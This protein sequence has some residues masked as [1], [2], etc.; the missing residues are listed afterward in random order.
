LAHWL[1]AQALTAAFF[2]PWM[3]LYLSGASTWSAAPAFDLG[4]FLR[5]VATVLPLGVTTH[6]E[7]YTAL[8]RLMTAFAALG[9]IGTLVT[10]RKG[11]GGGLFVLIVLFP[12][13]LIYLLSLTPA[14]FFAPKIQARYLLILLPAY[15]ILLA[16]GVMLLRRFSV[17]AALLAAAVIVGVNLWALGDYYAERRLNDD[18]ATLANTINALAQRDDVVLLNTDQE[19][20]TFLY[21][22]RPSIEWLGAPNGAPM[23]EENADALVRRALVRHP[24]VWVVSIPDALASD[25]QQLL[26]ARLVHDL[27]RQYERSF[28]DKRLEL[29]APEARNL[30]NVPRENFAPQ[31]VRAET[32]GAR[33]LIGF[34]LPVHE[35]R[36]GDTVHVVT[37]WDAQTEGDVAVELQ[38]VATDRIHVP[39]GERVRA[40][41]DFVL[42]PKAAGEVAVRVES[43]ELGR[44]R[45]EARAAASF[46]GAISHP[47]E[48]LFAGGIQL[49]GYD[50]PKEE[51]RAGEQVPITLYWRAGQPVPKSYVV[52]VHLLGADANLNHTPPNLLW[53]QVDRVPANGAAPTTLW[54]PNETIADAY[55]VP[56]ELGAPIGIYKIEVGL[57]DPASGARLPL[58]GLGD[59]LWLAEIEIKSGGD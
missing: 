11:R 5:L 16:L 28:G 9:A 23:S 43:V 38:N 53:G 40:E 41:A 48:F 29:Y 8:T 12:P 47:T 56:I 54:Q 20:P 21:Y 25:P 46:S 49:V 57:Y 35:A 1:A 45:V 2:A 32:L 7:D 18:Y 30:V 6:I 17:Y 10:R 22:L 50:L 55:R 24:A 36:V 52:F 3:Y 26:Q 4:L 59:S 39:A 31:R 58:H 27:P 51:F 15:A 42:S 34:D 19:W 33:Q 44:I 37:Y 13:F 14:S